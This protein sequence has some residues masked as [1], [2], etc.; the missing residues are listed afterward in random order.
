MDGAHVANVR[1]AGVIEALAAIPVVSTDVGGVRDARSDPRRR[2]ARQ[3]GGRAA[4]RFAMLPAMR[5]LKA[6][7]GRRPRVRRS[8]VTIAAF[9]AIP[10]ACGRRP[11]ASLRDSR[12]DRTRRE[13]RRH[14]LVALIHAALRGV[15]TP[16]LDAP[17]TTRLATS[18]GH[19][20]ATTGTFSSGRAAVRAGNH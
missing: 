9:I 12:V 15:S 1:D 3:R 2:G 6:D 20:L 17:G 18:S 8:A 13:S 7:A 19:V 11:V 10:Q 14:A 5:A 16:G 4:A